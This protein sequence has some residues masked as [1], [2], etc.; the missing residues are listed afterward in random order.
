MPQEAACQSIE[1]VGR[2]VMA[3]FREEEEKRMRQKAERVG[4]IIER[5]MKRKKEPRIPKTGRPTIVKASG[6]YG[7]IIPGV[8][9]K[10]A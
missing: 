9:D 6:G 4:P 10:K 5:A 8:T 7:G 3:E 1:L 2:E